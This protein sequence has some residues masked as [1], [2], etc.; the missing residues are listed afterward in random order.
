M[1]VSLVLIILLLYIFRFEES[2]FMQSLLLI[3]KLFFIKDG[4][5][6]ITLTG[7]DKESKVLI[8]GEVYCL[9]QKF[10]HKTIGNCMR[11]M[12]MSSDSMKYSREVW[13]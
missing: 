1:E 10:C 6:I 12:E 2:C 3:S 13:S 9:T 4:F 11:D 5:I 7:E 8:Y